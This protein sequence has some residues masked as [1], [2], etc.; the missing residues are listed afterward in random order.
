MSLRWNWACRQ[1]ISAAAG[2]II[3]GQHTRWIDLPTANENILSS[4]PA[5]GLDAQAVKET[6]ATLKNFGPLSYLIS[7]RAS[8][9]P[10]TAPAFDRSGGGNE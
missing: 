1:T 10:H 2:E 4:S 8:C 7:A 5:S 3:R 9:G 6:S